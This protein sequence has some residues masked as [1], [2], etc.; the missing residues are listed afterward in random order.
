MPGLEK[1]T[2]IEFD[3]TEAHLSR[4]LPCQLAMQRFLS[5]FDVVT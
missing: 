3:S 1:S 2:A 4:R 5:L